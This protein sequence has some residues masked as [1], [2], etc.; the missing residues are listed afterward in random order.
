VQSDS[1]TASLKNQRLSMIRQLPSAR[2]PPL[3]KNVARAW[4]VDHCSGLAFG[5]ADACTSDGRPPNMSP[6]RLKNARYPDLNTILMVSN[7]FPAEGAEILVR[8]ARR[9]PGQ[10][11]PAELPQAARTPGGFMPP[12]SPAPTS[13][14]RSS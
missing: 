11:D 2:G 13:R 9:A 6:Y 10:A 7:E 3:C 12:V 4:C 14:A 8:F 5:L 1:G